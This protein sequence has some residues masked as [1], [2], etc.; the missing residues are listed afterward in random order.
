VSGRGL[1]IR[2]PRVLTVAAAASF[3]LCGQAFNSTSAHAVPLP[4]VT[5][6]FSRSQW[7]IHENC[8]VLRGAITLQ[9]IASDLHDRGGIGTGSVVTS[10]IRESS[11]HCTRAA[12]Y[13][14]WDMLQQL[15]RDYG[16]EST[17]HSATHPNMTQLTRSQQIAQSCGTLPTFVNHGFNRAWGMFSY[18]NNKRSSEIQADVVSTCFA[19][20]RKYS[21]SRNTTGTMTAPWWAKVKSVNGGKCNDSAAACYSIAV[22]SRYE[23]PYTVANLVAV[24]PGQWAVA[25]FHKLVSG[26]RLSGATRW[27][28][29]ESDWRLHFTSRTELYCWNDYQR[30][31]NAIPADA[32]VTDPATVAR[33][34]GSNPQVLSRH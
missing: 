5:I 12:L 15:H 13:P 30:I 9:Q 4:F 14:S 24:S 11:I 8:N 23:S 1:A 3:V 32:I 18:P 16:W 31:L 6:L 28:C 33:A 7:A 17:S 29:S 20:G 21:P 25:Q 26:S 22:G 34:W 2:Y 19:F 27:D 10:W